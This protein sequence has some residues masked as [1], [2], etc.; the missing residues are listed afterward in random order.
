MIIPGRV[1]VQVQQMPGNNVTPHQVTSQA[2]GTMVLMSV[3]GLT[4]VEHVAALVS[5]SLAARMQAQPPDSESFYKEIGKISAD[6]AEAVLVECACR[7]AVVAEEVKKEKE[8]QL[9][10]SGIVSS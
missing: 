10:D 8:R 2:D 7:A 6:I 9:A 1:G 3:G 5:A 4:K